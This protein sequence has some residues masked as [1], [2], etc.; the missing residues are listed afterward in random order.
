M[1]VLFLTANIVVVACFFADVFHF[2]GS[3][4]LVANFF[5]HYMIICDASFHSDGILIPFI[6]I[7]DKIAQ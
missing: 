4:L 2:G 5:V 7:L 3:F 1:G 6:S